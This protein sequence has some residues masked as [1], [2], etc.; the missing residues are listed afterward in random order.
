MMKRIAAFLIAAGV[1][2]AACALDNTVS[3]AFWCTWGYVNG[4]TNVQTSAAVAVAVAKCRTDVA[5]SDAPAKFSTYPIGTAFT[6]R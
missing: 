5:Y 1:A 4:T 2:C 3:N 6:L